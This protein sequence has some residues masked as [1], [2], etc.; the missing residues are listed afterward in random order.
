VTEAVAAPVPDR[1]AAPNSTSR[2]FRVKTTST[3]YG[4]VS[5]SVGKI[6]TRATNQDCSRYSRQ[7][8]GGLN[9]NTSVSSAIAKNPP[10]ARMG[11]AAVPV[12]TNEPSPFGAI[13]D[14]INC[15]TMN[16]MTFNIASGRFVNGLPR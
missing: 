6:D 7:A 14:I 11:L 13:Y 2:M 5:I 10:T 16:C 3:V 15:M 1:S 8:N 12:A 9:I 4:M